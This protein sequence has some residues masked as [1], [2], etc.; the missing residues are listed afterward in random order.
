MPL[1]AKG[2]TILSHMMKEYHSKRKGKAVF[3]ASVNKGT[4]KGVEPTR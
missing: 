2:Q 3:Y 1:T 4:I